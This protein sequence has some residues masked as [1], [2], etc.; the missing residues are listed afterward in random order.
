MPIPRIQEVWPIASIAERPS[1][2]LTDWQV[3]EVKL[4]NH[5]SKTRHFV[6]YCLEDEFGQVSSAI[7]QFD[8]ITLRGATE[9]GRIYQLQGKPGWHADADHT[10]KRWKRISSVTVEVDVT[11]SLKGGSAELPS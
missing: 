3:F 5:S 2:T 10:W 11:D 8:P 4:P 6:G 1:V 9:S 7:Q